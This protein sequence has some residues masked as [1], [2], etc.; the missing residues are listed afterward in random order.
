M[1][2]LDIGENER[3]R[4]SLTSSY[5]CYLSKILPKSFRVVVF[6]KLNLILFALHDERSQLRETLFS[7]T[8][9]T[10]KHSITTGLSDDSA[11]S[12]N[13]L[14]GLIEEDKLQLIITRKV[15]IFLLIL[16]QLV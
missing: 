14:N 16:Q 1:R 10:N 7:T 5:L 6:N 15:V 4:L 11:D 13:L 8:S 12:E 3:Q 2:N 9:D